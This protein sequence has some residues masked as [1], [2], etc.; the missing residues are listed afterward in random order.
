MGKIKAAVVGYG[1]IGRYVLEALEVAPDFEIAGVVRRNATQIPAA[2]AAYRVVDSIA[3]LGTVDVAILCTPSR[4]AE[5]HAREI[6]AQG[7]NTV[8]SF[9]IHTDIVCVRSHLDAISK[10]HG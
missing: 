2:L 4:T 1:N 5:A 9:D 6:L 10:E 7:I 3:Q 8:D